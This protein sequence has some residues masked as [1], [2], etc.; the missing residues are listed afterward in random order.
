MLI[1]KKLPHTV[2]LTGIIL[3]SC[4][5]VMLAVADSITASTEI[6]NSTHTGTGLQPELQS[7]TQ[8]QVKTGTDANIRESQNNH[9]PN[10]D[11]GN[12]KIVRESENV[13]LDGGGSSDRDGDKLSYSWGLISPK[14]LKVKL[15]NANSADANFIAPTI[16]S[17][18]SKM[19]LVFKLTVSDGNFQD[20]DFVRI[21]VTPI[22]NGGKDN[23]DNNKI[24]T[25]TVIDTGEPSKDQLFASD[26][27]GAGTYAYS[28]LV[29]GVKWRT[30]PVTYA[31]DA[32]NSHI[33]INAAKTAVR[34]AF[35]AIDALNQP[36]G[37]FF[38][39]TSNYAAA[40]I[41]FT[42][43]YIDGLYNKLG[44]TTFSYRTDTKALTSATV[45]LDSGDKYFISPTERCGGSGSLFDIQ[46]IATHEIGHA[47][48]LGHVSDKL[49]SMYPSSLAGETVKR[50]LGNGDIR[51]ISNLY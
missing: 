29:S 6:H 44:Y 25:M 2:I 38:Q 8:G 7:D 51:G 11:A 48:N 22:D 9:P 35:G 45:T 41:K 40:K 19:T 30:F 24:R 47:I 27:C 18:R 49:Q 46:N 4:L 33:D 13:Q 31:I 42:W 43:K 28:Y 23:N 12:N 32:A 26:V 50:T 14:N 1:V 39:E 20:S 3:S 34:K 36:A 15:D 37:T 16:E 21:S 5:L 17:A 10:A